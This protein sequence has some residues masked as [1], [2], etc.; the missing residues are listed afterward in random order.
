MSLY[1]FVLQEVFAE[2]RMGQQLWTPP[3]C[4][5]GASTA[6]DWSFVGQEELV[7]YVTAHFDKI[8]DGQASS[9]SS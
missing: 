3:L 2:H 9:W 5:N 8:E 7:P 6:R 1:E 4:W